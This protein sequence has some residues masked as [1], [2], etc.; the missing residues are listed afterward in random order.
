MPATFWTFLIG[1]FALSGFP[2]I[3]AG[4]WSKDEILSGAFSSGQIAV[5]ITLALAALLTAFYTM[6][7]ITLTFLG[8]PRTKSAE[9]AHESKP[10][11]TVPLII[12]AFFAITAGW[13]GIPA[14][15]PA[16]GGLVP[17]WI[18][19]FLGSMLPWHGEVHAA[20]SLVPLFTS[21]IVALGGLFLGYLVYKRVTK[22]NMTDPLKASLGGIHTIL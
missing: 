22:A 16:I 2:L 13:I 21:L 12:L 8:E 20:H 19:E 14:A 10:T 18:E 17:N 5:F 4:F 9:H 6:R 11:M 1:G 7:Q 15:F 3:T